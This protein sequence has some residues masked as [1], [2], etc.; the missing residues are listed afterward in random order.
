[1]ANIYVE[2]I[3]IYVQMKKALRYSENTVSFVFIFNSPCTNLPEKITLKFDLWGEKNEA[4]FLGCV[5]G[6]VCRLKKL[7]RNVVAQ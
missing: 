4:R 3:D 1:M 2:Y 6:F 5:Y 7:Y